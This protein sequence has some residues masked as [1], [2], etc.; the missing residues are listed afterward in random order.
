MLRYIIISRLTNARARSWHVWTSEKGRLPLCAVDREGS[1]RPNFC[2]LDSNLSDVRARR[3]W[4]APLQ[5][6]ELV[7][8]GL[9]SLRRLRKL[10]KA[11]DYKGKL[12]SL[13]FNILSCSTF[14]N[15]PLKGGLVWVQSWSACLLWSCCKLS[16]LPNKISMMPA[17]SLLTCAL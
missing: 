9:T 5:A 15:K 8:T 1:K 4:E 2:R 12:A 3:R 13:N 14:W 16:Y 7:K 17:V 11:Y 10:R 6:I